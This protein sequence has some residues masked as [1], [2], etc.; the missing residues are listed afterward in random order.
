MPARY[1]IYAGEPLAAL[2]EGWHDNR[3][4]RVNA[5]ADAYRALIDQLVP[6]LEMSDWCALAHVAA[7][8]A[9]DDPASLRLFW[10]IV[11]DADKP[12]NSDVDMSALA[13]CVRA[14]P[15]PDLLAMREVLWRC[16]RA[17]PADQPLPVRL[18]AAGAKT[19]P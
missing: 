10:A 12:P 18:T 7:S 16:Q 6:V 5:V 8:H 17:T 9:L 14:L 15:L 4:G 1:P 13:D 19:P 3:S 2:L 11:A